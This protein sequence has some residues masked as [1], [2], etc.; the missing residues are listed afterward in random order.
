MVAAV[1]LLGA[2]PA[3]AAENASKQPCSCCSDGSVHEIDHP[4]REKAL[5][6]KD[7]TDRAAPSTT[8]HDPFVRN[9][10]FGG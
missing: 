3:L 5:Q 6:K 2:A 1:T 8:E 7:S 9:Q 10:S 4:L